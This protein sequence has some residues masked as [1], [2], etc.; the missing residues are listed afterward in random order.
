[1]GHFRSRVRRAAFAGLAGLLAATSATCDLARGEF[2]FERYDDP[3][4]DG[5]F[6][7]LPFGS[8]FVYVEP[9]RFWGCF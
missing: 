9:C 4:D 6:I 3:Y 1:M 2:Y 5:V 8:S 7:D